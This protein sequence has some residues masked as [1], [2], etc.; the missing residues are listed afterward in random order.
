MP[1]LK[2]REMP[3]D[4][5][6][7]EKLLARGADAL[8]NAELIAILLRT[9][10]RGMNVVDVARELLDKYK[11]FAELSRCSVKELRRNQ[12]DRSGEGIRTGGGIQFGKTL[13]AGTVVP[14]K[15][16]FT[17]T[18]L[19]TAGRRNADAADRITA[20]CPARHAIPFDAN[21]ISV[22]WKHE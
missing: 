10:R 8:S 14:A 18:D 5:R 7:R 9:G 2:I 1:Q 3:Q 15:T 16:R 17:G 11:S 4:E 20:R 12:R 13:H 6:P 21:R 22:G 19:Q